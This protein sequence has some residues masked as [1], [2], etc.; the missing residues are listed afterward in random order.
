M[1]AWCALAGGG[2]ESQVVRRGRDGFGRAAVHERCKAPVIIAKPKA[3]PK[4]DSTKFLEDRR[5][6]A[7]MV[8]IVTVDGSS[9]A[10][11]SST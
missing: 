8:I 2:G 11:K 10:Q 7:G 6:G 5:G 4:L 1:G 9:I 3:V